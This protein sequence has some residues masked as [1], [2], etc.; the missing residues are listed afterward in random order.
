M[1]ATLVTQLDLRMPVD[2]APDARS[3]VEL[4]PFDSPGGALA[5][6]AW[7]SMQATA[8]W[9]AQLTKDRAKPT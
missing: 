4:H 9:S 8:P 7:K 6:T 2:A 1:T 5:S 3:E